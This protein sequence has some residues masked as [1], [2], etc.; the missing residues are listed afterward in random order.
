MFMTKDEQKE[1]MLINMLAARNMVL[2]K[3]PLIHLI[4]SPI[5]I[6]DCAN[7]ILA[8]GGRPICAEHPEEV[9]ASQRFPGHSA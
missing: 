6:N 9:R 7:A 1:M 3:Q 2:E 4:T 5:A 8:V